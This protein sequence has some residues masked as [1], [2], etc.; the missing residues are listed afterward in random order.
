MKN[1]FTNIIEGA[2]AGA[3]IGSAL[4]AI[5][6]TGSTLVGGPVGLV[7]GTAVAIS[8]TAAGTL[9]G[10]AAGVVKTIGEEVGIVQ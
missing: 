7:A 6:I 9:I 10:G 2:T 5:T 4:D 3:L 1:L 8:T